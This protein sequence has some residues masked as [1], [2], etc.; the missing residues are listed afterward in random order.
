MIN[1]LIVFAV[2]LVLLA[3]AAITGYMGHS[4][5]N[6]IGAIYEITAWSTAIAGGVM[7]SVALVCFVI[8]MLLGAF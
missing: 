2:G 3:I 1:I 6:F 5:F 4:R 7:A 8:K